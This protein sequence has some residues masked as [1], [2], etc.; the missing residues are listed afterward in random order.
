MLPKKNELPD[1]TYEAKKITRFM[2]M[3]YKKIHAF[4][5]DYILYRKQYEH[6][7]K[8]PVSE[9]SQYKTNKK[10]STKVL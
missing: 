10:F 9:R 2:S 7:D 8:Y 4:P 3:N 1:R 6:L 5:N